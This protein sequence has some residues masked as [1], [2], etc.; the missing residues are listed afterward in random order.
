VALVPVD[1]PGV[2]TIIVLPPCPLTPFHI[3]TGFS[4]LQ[5]G[6]QLPRRE[7][8]PITR[9]GPFFIFHRSRVSEVLQNTFLTMPVP[10]TLPRVSLFPLVS[11]GLVSCRGFPF[12]WSL[13][14]V[15]RHQVLSSLSTVS[16]SLSIIIET[17]SSVSALH[18]PL[19][20]L[21]P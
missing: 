14:P 3:S 17:V 4:H 20:P 15:C 6:R 2:T 11:L 8:T 7:S 18:G 10:P 13:F 9:L 21:F 5:E 1:S 12:P 16:E 19:I